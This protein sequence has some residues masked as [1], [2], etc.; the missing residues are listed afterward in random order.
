M[1]NK[2]YAEMWATYIAGNEEERQNC[3]AP[4]LAGGFGL[5][6]GDLYTNEYGDKVWGGLKGYALHQC[7]VDMPKELAHKAVEIL[8]AAWPEVVQLWTDLEEAFKQVLMRG[9]IVKVGEV[10]WD[11]LT[12]T[13]VEH[14][15]KGQQCVLTFTRISME[16]GGYIIRMELPSG[17]G[18]HYIN[19]TIETEAKISKKGNPYTARTIYYD[20]IEHSATKGADGKNNKKRMK[21]GRV[22]TNG[23][24]LCEN[25]D[26]AISRDTLL[27]G[28]FLAD[29]MGFDLWGIF[30]DEAAAEVDND[31]FG[32][33]LDDLIWCLTQTPEWAKGLILGA[34][35]WEGQV[36][37]K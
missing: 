3:K 25:G 21:W 32:L 8:R 18:L 13:W 36:Y 6:G 29:N 4:V 12:R 22:R 27:N 23:P 2:T 5:G 11:Q 14:H 16:G 31:C 9:G 17:R 1:Y 33:Q 19:A 24:K 37:K 10:T 28:L 35:G 34:D 26:Q 7:G 15:T 30:H 20:G